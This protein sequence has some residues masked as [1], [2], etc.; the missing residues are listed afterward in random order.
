MNETQLLLAQTVTQINI[1]QE[2]I[3]TEKYRKWHESSEGGRPQNDGSSKIG[4]CSLS[5][6]EF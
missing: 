6:I 4:R 1:I 5:V 3:A 2:I